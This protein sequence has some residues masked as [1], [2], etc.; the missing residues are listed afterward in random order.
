MTIPLPALH[1]LTDDAILAR[2]DFEAITLDLLVVLQHRFALHVRGHR[3]SATRLFE[4][5]NNL[6][7]RAAYVRAPLFINDRIDIARAFDGVGV[8][9]G[10]G[11]LPLPTARPLLDGRRIGYSA[12]GAAEAALAEAEGADFIL[13]G[14]IFR[15]ASHPDVEPGGTALLS[16][17][18]DACRTPV[19]AIGGVTAEN[20]SGVLSTGAYG[21]A[22][23]RAV[24]DAPDPVPAAAELVKLL[25]E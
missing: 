11:S 12:H 21:A 3:T 15:T 19:L 2:P 24:W 17:V 5:V 20:V 4:L 6:A 13:A 25:N 10:A 23:I 1:I 8:Q 16:A 14:T 18:V 9:L 7:A 22:V